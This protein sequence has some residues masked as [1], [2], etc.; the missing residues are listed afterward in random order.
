MSLINPFILTGI[1]LA[2]IPVI[3]HFM[4]RAKPKKLMFPALRLI[5][6]RRA[7]NVRRL[8]LRHI[9]LLL[10]R[11]T[12][13]SLLV[14]A[15]A[16]PSVPAA[17]YAPN[18]REWLTILVI[19]LVAIGAYRGTLAYWRTRRLSQVDLGY[20]RSLL[21]GGTGIGVVLLLLL[22]F[23]WPYQQRIAAEIKAPSQDVTGNLPVATVFLFDTS[24]S[25]A[26]RLENDTRLEIAQQISGAHLSHLPQ[27]SRVAITDTSTD[28]PVFFQADRSGAQARIESLEI[29]P[30]S[31]PLNDR[32]RAAAE[33]LEDDRER[34]LEGQESVSEGDRLD[35][36]L[37]E[38]Y[39]FTDLSATGWRTKGT[40]SLSEKLETLQWLRVYII[41]V[42]VEQ[43]T[44]IGITGLR[45]SQQ[46]VP[47]GGELSLVAELTAL[48][49]EESQRTAELYLEGEAMVA[50]KQDR[51]TVS[52]KPD[53][54]ALIAFD[55]P[56]LTG[57][58]QHGEVRLVSS[59]PFA[60]DDVRYFSV[61][62][63][64]PPEVLIVSDLP[65][66]ADYLDA[67]LAPEN[68]SKQGKARYRCTRM[69]SNRLA[70][71]SL[72]KYDVV[73]LVNVRRP[74]A[75]SWNAL[76][77]FTAAGGGLGVV[78]G[79]PNE[80]VN[81][82]AVAYNQDEALEVLPGELLADLR[83]DPPET[84]DL[85]DLSHPILKVFDELGGRE[86]LT[87][88]DVNRY[89]RVTPSENAGVVFAYTD[90]RESP[91]L[92]ERV[93]GEG[94]V[95]MLTTAVDPESWNDLASREP[96][97]FI[98]LADQMTYY[99]AGRS[100]SVFNYIAGESPVL[101]LDGSEGTNQFLLRKPG[102]QQTSL[103]VEP[104]MPSLTINNADQIG[105]YR[106]IPREGDSPFTVGFSVNASPGESDFAPMTTEELDNVLGEGRYSVSKDIDGLAANVSIGRIGQEMFP[107]L[108]LF[109]LV[110]FCSEH[111]VANHFYDQD[112]GNT[113]NS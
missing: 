65:D 70:E 50:V 35:Q 45:L 55:I 60:P 72:D 66:A 36:Y 89:W 5:H 85:R 95:L 62:I 51:A 68:S 8:R 30:V 54:G 94:R 38:V 113:D 7:T 101:S 103:D 3:L 81:P 96:W 44:N 24:P 26:Y 41:D 104:D 73:Y 78:L 67:A 49:V 58:A 15:I 48:G 42:G 20:R 64:P 17:N 33:L 77:R 1:G 83:F 71:A 97:T 61:S 111:I 110:V 12:V 102:L 99:L 93:F 80:Q 47:R 75:S 82:V 19:G 59:D 57:T 76:A 22:L 108:L 13:I 109:L 40:R 14:L 106:V 11:V 84:F 86:Q 63:Q 25:M 16:R 31:I 98:A 53:A 105:H 87:T 100:K 74:T 4:M 29:R 91:A 69:P 92:L 112:A 90:Y 23:I 107:F 46:T 39:I 18:G 21:R 27:R 79:M 6:L 56:N 10:L 88:V 9:W 52:V 32:I 37:R 2:V 43:P 28:H 34:T